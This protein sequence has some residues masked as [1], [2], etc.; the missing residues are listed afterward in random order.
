MDSI[1][2]GLSLIIAIGAAVALIMRIIGQPLI[3][4]HIITGIIVGPAVLHIA[5]SPDTLRL[6]SDI[7]IALLLFIIGLG[8]NPKVVKE[9]G[10]TA[11]SVGI[12]QVVVITVLGW[13][14][15]SSLGLNHNES[16]FLGV[17]LAISST[18]IILKLLSDKKEQGRLYGKIA[19]SV[20]L[21]QDI[22]A[23]ALVVLTSA[24][25]NH[26]TLAVGSLFGLIIKA[27]I[28]GWL[29]Y[30]ISYRVLPQFQRIIAGS[31]E[32]LFLFAIAWGLGS[33]AL[34]AKIGLSSEIGALLAGICLAPLP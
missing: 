20:S 25:T 24:A 5:K 2:S 19:I 7:G 3:I 26:Q 6:F 15:G 28:V 4:G 27:G 1:F 32:F 13:I 17:S 34:F 10:R 30:I 12:T 21:V 31:Q 11:T 8:L 16:L 14:V 23:I 9:V 33:A 22:I 18:I 29:I